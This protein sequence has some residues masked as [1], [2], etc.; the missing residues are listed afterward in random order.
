MKPLRINVLGPPQIELDNQPVRF[1]S[2]KAVALLAYLATMPGHHPR[3]E[4]ALL[5]WSESDRKRALGALR[6]TLSKIK[7][8]LGPDWLTV[9]AHTLSLAWEHGPEVDV[10]RFRDVL[11]AI[12]TTPRAQVHLPA[13]I[14]ELEAALT[15]Y[16]D[17]FLTGFVLRDAV[18][19][20]EWHFFQ[21]ETVRQELAGALSHLMQL[22]VRRDDGAAAIQAGLRLLQLDPLREDI[23][24]EVMRL[25][26]ASGQVA[27][28]LRQYARFVDLLDRELGVAPSSGTVTLAAQLR[29]EATA[30]TAVAA[31]QT[32]TDSPLRPH[33]VPVPATGFVGRETE[34]AELRA[35]LA[36]PDC[37]LISVIG[38][39]GMGK[40][41][42]VQHVAY[43][44]LQ[45][46]MSNFADGLFFVSL[47]AVT[48]A[49]LLIAAI[50]DALGFT[51]AGTKQPQEQ[52]FGYLHTKEVLLVLDNL[53]QLIPVA[54]IL[55]TLLTNTTSLKLLVTSRERLNLYEE[56]LLEVNGLALPDMALAPDAAPHRVGAYSAIQLFSQRARRINPRFHPHTALADIVQICR[57]VDGM[58]LGIELAA[59]W[60]RTLSCREIVEQIQRNLDFLVTE[61][62]DIPARHRS[63]RAVFRHSWLRLS[64]DEREVFARLTVFRGGFDRDAAAAIAGASQLVLARLVDK[65]MLQRTANAHLIGDR[66]LIHELL[67]QF[68]WLELSPA[69]RCA[70]QAAHSAY[71]AAF[72]QA[73]EATQQRAGE[74]EAIQQIGAEMDNVAA[75]WHWLIHALKAALHPAAN[76]SGLADEGSQC[77]L[78]VPTLVALL[79]QAAPMLACFFLR[80][81]RFREG[82]QLFADAILAIDAPKAADAV[83]VA[84]LLARLRVC[85]AEHLF[86]LSEFPEVIVLVEQALPSLRQSPP[87]RVLAQGLWLIG[88]ARMRMGDYD[89]AK[90]V[91]L[92]SLATFKSAG[93][94]AAQTLAL[95]ALGIVLSNQ[96][97]FDQARPYYEEFLAISRTMGYVRGV[98]NA[99][100][101]LGS[102]YARTGDYDQARSFYDQSHHLSVASGEN[103]MIAVTLSNLGSVE[104]ALAHHERARQYYAESLTITRAIG[105]RRWTAANL[106]G[107]SLT[108]LEM[109][110]P[111]G[112]EPLVLE[113]LQIAVEIHSNPDVLDALA[114]LGA[115]LSRRGESGAA[116]QLAHLVAAHPMTLTQARQR[117]QLLADQLSATL[118][119][120]TAEE[121]I[122]FAP[123]DD[124]AL[125]AA[126]I[127]RLFAPA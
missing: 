93:E 85:Q 49:D 2:R 41:R 57:L 71:Y 14:A 98:A 122:D 30:S 46:R 80:R 65:T 45:E 36:A 99:L 29:Q 84:P 97:L 64:N 69:Q 90:P 86:N 4:L 19:F 39:G 88:L 15:L 53:E 43:Q 101:N 121:Q 123:T 35:L 5:L 18:N 87:T 111:D 72:L 22:H 125:V 75:A 34:V 12:D 1:E 32:L 113:A 40:T 114:I 16:R 83:V 66:Y 13:Q 78:D 50:A 104:R 25:Q 118:G 17:D 31:P 7:A 42:L 68:G 109:D 59:G 124:L 6:Y 100:N 52:L 61:T 105:E 44:L 102:N 89:G 55:A 24:R 62:Q 115:I 126:R 79:I 73:R 21:A 11:R 127:L 77:T 103:L 27:A 26:A 3:A 33:K 28:A 94:V 48:Q 112:A 8:V 120:A 106:N 91:L 95:N 60:I 110:A 51:F 92:E 82:A 37:R 20:E 9:D 23:Q 96:G 63:V 108:L 74:A 107:L 58:P 76:S 47:A 10:S 116:Y 119:A 70:V 81:S 67:R 56:W 117:S 54:A 38:P